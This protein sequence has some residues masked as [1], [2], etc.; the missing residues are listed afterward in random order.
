MF[1]TCTQCHTVRGR[2]FSLVV[3]ALDGVCPDPLGDGPFHSTA[4]WQACVHRERIHGAISAQV[5][6]EDC[7]AISRNY[8]DTRGRRRSFHCMREMCL[9]SLEA[10]L[11][12]HQ[13][14]GHPIAALF[15]FEIVHIAA[16]CQ[17]GL[18]RGL[19]RKV[20][21]VGIEPLTAAICARTVSVG[22]KSQRKNRNASLTYN[23][24]LNVLMC[25]NTSRGAKLKR[26]GTHIARPRAAPHVI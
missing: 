13:E 18:H 2:S 8:L 16:C 4:G 6:K 10:T 12:I 3:T 25:Q 7:R 14:C 21:V 1:I 15:G 17:E 19:A 9:A 5:V 22:Q 24:T 11:D 20:V 23:K 26:C